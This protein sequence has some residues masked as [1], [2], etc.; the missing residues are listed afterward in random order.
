MHVAACLGQPPGAGGKHALMGTHNRIIG[1]GAGEYL[2][3]IAIDP[4]APPPDRARWFGLD[5]LEGQARLGGWVVRTDDIGGEVSARSELGDVLSLERGALRWRMAV[6]RDGRQPF[7][8]CMP[9][10]IQWDSD[11]PSLEASGVRLTRLD[12]HHPRSDGLSAALSGLIDD[13]RLHVATGPA[14]LIATFDTPDGPRIL[15]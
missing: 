13:D 3:A 7:D 4:D 8:G 14:A 5:R 12:L 1:L 9:A 6:P 10:V 15:R 2:E 11:P